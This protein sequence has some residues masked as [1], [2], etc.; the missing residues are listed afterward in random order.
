MNELWI[1][2]GGLVG[3]VVMGIYLHFRHLPIEL[4][5]SRAAVERE[6]NREIRRRLDGALAEHEA[7][8]IAN[9]R[10]MNQLESEGPK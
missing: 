2:W 1:L 10:A 5:W 9:R 8:L 3:L 7:E 4:P 6:I